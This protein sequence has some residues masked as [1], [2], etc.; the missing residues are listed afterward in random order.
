MNLLYFNAN[1]TFLDCNWTI[2]A[3]PKRSLVV[4]DNDNDSVLW[5]ER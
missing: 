4:N 3:N 1:I 2:V 5:H